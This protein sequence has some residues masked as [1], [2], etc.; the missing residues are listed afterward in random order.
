MLSTP[1]DIQIP[2]GTNAYYALL[3]VKQDSRLDILTVYMLFQTW[4]DIFRKSAENHIVEMKLKWWAD[5]I[6]RVYTGNTAHPLAKALS[7]IIH[8]FEIPELWFQHILSCY[9][10][11]I[12]VPQFQSREDFNYFCRALFGTKCAILAKIFASGSDEANDFA[13]LLGQNIYLIH[14]IRHVGY[15]LSQGRC[16]FPTETL[17]EFSLTQEE[18]FQQQSPNKIRA[19]L[20][21]ESKRAR[22]HYTQ[23]LAAL[24]AQLRFSQSSLLIFA[25][26]YLAL[27]KEIERD[28]YQHLKQKYSLTPLRKYWLAWR[29]YSHENK[30][31]IK[32]FKN[33]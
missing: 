15:H 31:R 11:D 3:Y 7:P 12:Q 22:E 5:E 13:Y 20:E 6:H 24:P 2:R 25:N 23:A 8:R 16:Y 26:L 14:L 18:L 32:S 19:L 28:Q 27:L 1:H 10:Q 9:I 33:R 30:L 17:S 29:T 21:L 4:H